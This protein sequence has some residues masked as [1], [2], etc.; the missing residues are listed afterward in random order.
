M[1]S[2]R[3]DSPA[4]SNLLCVNVDNNPVKGTFIEPPDITA[5]AF[6]IAGVQ[7]EHAF[8]VVGAAPSLNVTACLP[9]TPPLSCHSV[10]NPP[11]Y[12][13]TPVIA[14]A[15]MHRSSPSRTH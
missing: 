15:T 8:Q 13:P 2:M 10:A 1:G 14:V 9:I 7:P 5:S 11:S 3:V 4:L 6:D 12:L